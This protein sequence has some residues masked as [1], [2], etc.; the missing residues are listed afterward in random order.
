MPRTIPEVEIMASLEFSE[1]L[2]GKDYDECKPNVKS[3]ETK[4]L[5]YINIEDP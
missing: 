5:K 2:N 4:A 1:E 3:D